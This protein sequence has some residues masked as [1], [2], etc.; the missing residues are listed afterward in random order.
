MAAAIEL[1]LQWPVD[2]VAAA[3]VIDGD[4][5]IVGAVDA[6]FPL[7]SITKL[8]TALAILVAVEEGTVGLDEDVAPRVRLPALAPLHTA[9]LLSHSSG[10]GPDAPARRL[11]AP[12][13]RRIYSNAGYEIAAEA[14]A[15][16]SGMAFEHYL[17][18]A[19]CAPLG[20]RSTTLTGS[21][22]SGAS[23]TIS[24]LVAFLH[25]LHTPRLISGTTHQAMVTPRHPGLNGILPGF[26]RHAD[27]AWG[28]GPEIRSNKS[29][30]WTSTRNSPETFGHFGR[31]GSCLWWDPVVNRGAVA[32]T[33][34][35][36]GDWAIDA[37]PKL[38]DAILA[39]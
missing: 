10:L 28:L 17:G 27:N 7:A 34:R 14:V 36:F 37:W 39:H 26:G 31:A 19:V 38:A 15:R 3:S 21:P 2:E 12:A 5:T 30:H 16:S 1:V 18:E 8:M 35:P 29:P 22:A 25:E 32:L 24:D 6:R 4:V 23:S 11:V 20:M 9:D 33:T 13:E